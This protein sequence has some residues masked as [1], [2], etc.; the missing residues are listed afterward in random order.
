[1]SVINPSSSLGK[2][3]SGSEDSWAAAEIT[4][5]L[6]TKIDEITQKRDDPKDIV[7]PEQVGRVIAGTEQQK[8]RNRYLTSSPFHNPFH[9]MRCLVRL[10]KFWHRGNNTQ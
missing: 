6:T 5:M 2:G 10:E 8:R 1:M 3:T 4:R 7:P 9:K